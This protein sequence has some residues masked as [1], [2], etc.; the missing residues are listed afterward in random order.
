MLRLIFITSFVTSILLNIVFIF[1]HLYTKKTKVRSILIRILILTFTTFYIG[2]ICELI[3]YNF[4][5][6][7]DGFAFTLASRRWFQKYWYPI[8]SYGYRDNDHKSIAGKMNLFIV[9]DF[10]V[11]GHGIKDYRDRFTNLL[12]GK[13]GGNWEVYNIVKGGWSTQDEYKALINYPIKPD[14]VIFSYFINDIEGAAREVGNDRPV[15]IQPPP[16]IFAMI[17]NRSY[18]LNYIYWK[19]Y[20]IKFAS[21]MRDVYFGYLENAFSSPEIWRAHREDLLDL[22]K[23]AQ[24]KR[25]KMIF[26]LFPNLADINSSSK[27]TAQIGEFL[28]GESVKVINLARYLKGRNSKELIVSPFDA[29]PNVSLHMEVANLLYHHIMNEEDGF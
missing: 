18:F 20:R 29:H 3:F 27:L 6:Q 28:T 1:R 2:L 19:L 17:L 8:N 14:V 11:N 23:Y 9:G 25:A 10:F 26:L 24:S 16:K 12:A 7:S 21:N 13:L 5:I 22:I 4:F 15:L